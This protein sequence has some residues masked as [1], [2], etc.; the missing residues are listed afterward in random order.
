MSSIRIEYADIKMSVSDILKARFGKD[1]YDVI[2]DFPRACFMTDLHIAETESIMSNHIRDEM[3]LTIY[4]FPSSDENYTEENLIVQGNLRDLIFV[5][6][7]GL[8]PVKDKFSLEVMD[9]SSAV[10]DGVL[11]LKIDLTMNHK[12]IKDTHAELMEE[13][14]VKYNVDKN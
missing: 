9:Y 11:Q 6:L 7:N 12:I 1:V 5:D 2:E 3:V 14:S 8:I 4:Y 13:L 10:V